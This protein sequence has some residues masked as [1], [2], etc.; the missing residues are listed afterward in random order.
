MSYPKY[1]QKITS[2]KI[3]LLKLRNT[4]IKLITHLFIPRYR[5]LIMMD[6]V[7]S[8][9]SLIISLSPILIRRTPQRKTGRRKSQRPPDGSKDASALMVTVNE[10]A[11]PA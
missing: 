8:R 3:C 1:I 5:P 10:A 7:S 6:S 11:A 4:R 2:T 9:G